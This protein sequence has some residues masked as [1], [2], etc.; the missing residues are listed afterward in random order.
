[1]LRA[2][3]SDEWT[4]YEVEAA[5]I[6]YERRTEE[7]KLERLQIRLHKK[8]SESEERTVGEKAA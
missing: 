4:P 5:S 2:H 3:A 8:I 6:S 7:L 1:M